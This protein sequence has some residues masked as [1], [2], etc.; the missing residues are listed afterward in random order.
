[1]GF[2]WIE[3]KENSI[4]IKDIP[5]DE[6]RS[7]NCNANNP[8]CTNRSSQIIKLCWDIMNEMVYSGE[9]FLFNN[10]EYYLVECTNCQ[11]YYI[12]EN[13]TPKFVCEECR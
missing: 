11:E 5:E 3:E 2:K 13:K 8:G 7:M 1:M 4:E 6:G 9:V 10:K 12:I